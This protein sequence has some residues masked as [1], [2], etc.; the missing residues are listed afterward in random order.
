MLWLTP[1]EFVAFFGH[2]FI[3]VLFKIN[4]ER[5]AKHFNHQQ[6]STKE[7]LHTINIA[8]A[9]QFRWLINA[10]YPTTNEDAPCLFTFETWRRY[11]GSDA[12]HYYSVRRFTAYCRLKRRSH[13]VRLILGEEVD[14]SLST[15][16]HQL[17]S[18]RIVVT[19]DLVLSKRLKRSSI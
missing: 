9:I 15:S 2:G 16:T 7:T 13:K 3:R 17:Q 18:V 11:Y 4:I 10:R 14:A 6:N 5:E 19:N 8:I 1:W 12:F